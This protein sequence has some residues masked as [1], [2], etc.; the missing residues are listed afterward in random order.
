VVPV[1][2]YADGFIQVTEQ[3]QPNLFKQLHALQFTLFP[4]YQLPNPAEILLITKSNLPGP[5]LQDLKGTDFVNHLKNFLG[6]SPRLHLFNL[7]TEKSDYIRTLKELRTFIYDEGSPEK[8]VALLQQKQFPQ[9]PEN[10]T[11][12]ALAEAQVKITASASLLPTSGTAPDHLLRLFAY[13]DIM[14]KINRNYF[15]RN[16]ATEELIAE[17]ATANVVS[18]VSSLI[19]LETQ[20][21]YERFGITKS[22]NSLGNATAKAAGSVPEPHEWLLIMLAVA[23]IGYL[24]LKPFLKARLV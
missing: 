15:K 23:T 8:L 1:Y 22:K 20:Q 21:D 24:L 10:A 7:S 19:V 16:A 4:V 13:N 6:A 9:D 14:K 12:V 17:A 2:V 18:P 11:T 5:N 3:N